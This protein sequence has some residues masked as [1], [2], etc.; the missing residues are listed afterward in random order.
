[1]EKRIMLLEGFGAVLY[2]SSEIYRLFRSTP[3]HSGISFPAVETEKGRYAKSLGVD[4]LITCGSVFYDMGEMICGAHAVN[5]SNLIEILSAL[6]SSIRHSFPDEVF[7]VSP[8]LKDYSAA[9]RK[10]FRNS[11]MV[12]LRERSFLMSIQ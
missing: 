12:G 9:V 8:R 11:V 5:L 6:N 1:M 4:D 10:M 7:L 3:S 2:R